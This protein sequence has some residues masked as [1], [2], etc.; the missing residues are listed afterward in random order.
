MGYSPGEIERE[1]PHDPTG[2]CVG[3]V[4]KALR[5]IGG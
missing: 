4:G 2:A 5:V 3:P 1:L